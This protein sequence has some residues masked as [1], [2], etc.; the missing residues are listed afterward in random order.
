MFDGVDAEVGFQVGFEVEHVGGV[1]GLF[2]DDFEHLGDNTIVSNR[3]RSCSVGYTRSRSLSG[4]QICH[5]FGVCQIGF[6]ADE[7]DDV[8]EGGVVAEGE[9]VVAFDGVFLADGGERFGLFDG[10]DAEVGFQVE[11][12]VEHVGRIPGLRGDDLQHLGGYYITCGCCCCCGGTG[13]RSRS[14]SHQVRSFVADEADDVV[15]GGVVAEG[16]VVVAFDGVFLADGGERFGLF[17][18]VDAEVGFQVEVEVEHVGR[19]PGLR[20]HDLQNPIR[21]LVTRTCRFGD[22][23]SR[24]L[25]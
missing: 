11:V 25:S 4:A 8:V 12:E 24:C 5:R 16:E 23:G 2:G 17:D 3:W 20:R 15:E 10:V 6:V 7:A 14:G 22:C 9:V 1:A 13:G 21:H 18:G 19:I